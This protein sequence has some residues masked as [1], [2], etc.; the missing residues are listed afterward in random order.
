MSLSAILLIILGVALIGNTVVG[1]L[2]GKIV[3]YAKAHGAAGGST[4]SSPSSTP[5][6]S[7]KAKAAPKAAPKPGAGH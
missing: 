1:N 4:A 7:H 2:S 6:S 3:D 5:S